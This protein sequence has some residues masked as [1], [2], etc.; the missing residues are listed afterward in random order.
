MASFTFSIGHPFPVGTVVYAYRDL[1]FTPGNYRPPGTPAGSG[2]VAVGGGLVLTGLSEE[3]DYWAVGQIASVWRWVRVKID[4]GTAVGVEDRV[5]SLEAGAAVTKEA[6]LNVRYPEYGAVGDGVTDE[7]DA[8]E[9]WKTALTAARKGSGFIPK[10]SYRLP[11]SFSLESEASVEIFGEGCV[12]DV[13]GGERG[14][15]LNFIGDP[16]GRQFDLRKVKSLDLRHLTV[17]NANAT[18]DGHVIDLQNDGGSG[19]T[20]TRDVVLDHVTVFGGAASR[21]PSSGLYVANSHGITLR[22]LSVFDCQVGL[23]GRTTDSEYVIALVLEGGMFQN[24]VLAHIKNMGAGV[25]GFRGG[26]TKFGGGVRFEPLSNG[27]AGAYRHDVGVLADILTFDHAW[28]GDVSV[29][30]DPQIMFGGY[31]LNVLACRLGQESGVADSRII[32][33]D[34]NDSES[35]IV[36][37]NEAIGNAANPVPMLVDF[38]ATTGHETIHVGPN[39]L[40]NVTDQVGG[41]AVPQTCVTEGP[42]GMVFGGSAAL[43][44]GGTGILETG[45]HFRTAAEKNAYVGGAMNLWTA[46]AAADAPSNSI[47]LDEADDVLKKKDDGGVVTAL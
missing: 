14:T 34:A 3:T 15:V 23:L 22:E 41:V 7:A 17:V 45:A 43:Y 16:G 35:I 39:K 26:V 12:R 1:G 31:C 33:I 9:A 24:N 4:P 27:K 6:P 13:N 28:F 44:S 20:D 38:A 8:F 19:A 11:G 47:F 42:D 2:T 5:D 40:F 18:F 36:V 29:G 21:L 37:G 30:T 25:A 10:G 32:Q 46:I